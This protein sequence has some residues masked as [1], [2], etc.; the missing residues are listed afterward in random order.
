MKWGEDVLH[1]YGL[2]Q[3][4]KHCI[5]VLR[6]ALQPEEGWATGKGCVF[7]FVD[8]D[9]PLLSPQ[10]VSIVLFVLFLK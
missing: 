1:F 3:E 2:P 9:V 4:G 6:C 5:R 7:V 10:L 8:K